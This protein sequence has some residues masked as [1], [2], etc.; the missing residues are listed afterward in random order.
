MIRFETSAGDLRDGALWDALAALSADD[1]AAFPALRPHQR[2]PVHAFF[3]QVSAIAL[4]RAG[5]AALAYGR[6]RRAT[7]S[8]R[9]RAGDPAAATAPTSTAPPPAAQRRLPQRIPPHRKAEIKRCIA[10][11][12]KENAPAPTVRAENGR[13]AGPRRPPPRARRRPLHKLKRITATAYTEGAPLERAA[14]SW[15]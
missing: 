7:A 9:P 2:M 3:V 13:R 15:R 12:L 5:R 4:R 1:V 14:K 10:F 6:H 11:P 8:L